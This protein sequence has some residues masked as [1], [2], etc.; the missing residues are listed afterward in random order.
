MKK[1]L[2]YFFLI[3]TTLNA[4]GLFKKFETKII[5]IDGNTAVIE[6]SDDITIGSTGIILHKFD[7]D[8]STIV[9]GADVISKD[10]NKAVIKFRV[11]DMLEQKALPIPAIAPKVGDKVILN[12]LYD[13]ALIVAPNYKVYKNVTDHFKNITWIHSDLMGA[14]LAKEYKPN[15]NK[16]TFHT[17][18]K[19]NAT[20]L[21]FFALSG[22]GYFVDCNNFKVLKE[23]KSSRVR[24]A[25]LPFYTRVRGIETTWL[26]FD[27][28]EMHSYSRY[29]RE[30]L[31]L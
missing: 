29:Y 13:R 28:S 21:I 1:A 8:T 24:R 11:Y 17:M 7:K 20:S 9:A 6:N 27:S 25:Q 12:Y 16:K 4:Q 30:M 26:S 10:K 15:P 18:C 2:L 14:Y 22:N 5:S 19:Q 31:G 3:L 23:Y